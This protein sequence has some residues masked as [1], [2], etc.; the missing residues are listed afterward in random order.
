MP[1]WNGVE[2][3]GARV[4][5]QVAWDSELFEQRGHKIPLT[6]TLSRREREQLWRVGGTV[7]RVGFADR[8]ATILPL[9]SG[10]G[11]GEGN[12]G[13]PWEN[14]WLKLMTSSLFLT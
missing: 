9:P 5:R 2:R 11:R 6:P 1:A 12:W 14:R 10:E 4:R 3:E 8:L 7:K 13:A